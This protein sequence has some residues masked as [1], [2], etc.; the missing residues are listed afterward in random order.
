MTE[1]RVIVERAGPPKP[2]VGQ[3]VRLDVQLWRPETGPDPLP[4]FSFDEIEM[5][6]A[7]TL[8]RPE[9]PPPEER[10]EGDVK[11]L[12]QHRTLLV[13]PQ[14]DG[15]LTV[16]P[17][18][19]R[20]N[21]GT[22]ARSAQSEPL[23]FLASY[24]GPETDN[25]L[26]APNVHLEQNTNRALSGLRVGD[27]FTRTVKLSAMDSDPIV[28]PTLEFV[29][30]GG[31]ALYSNA[32]HAES[33]AERG[34][35]TASQSYSVTYVVERV[36]HYELPGLSIRYLEPS[37]GRFLRTE[38]PA[39]DFWVAPNPHLGLAMWGTAPGVAWLGFGLPLVLLVG[40]GGL[41]LRRKRNGPWAWEQRF[42]AR[43]VEQRAFAS[44]LKTT[45]AGTAVRILEATYAWL[46]LRLPEN[47]ERTLR[48]LRQ[49]CVETAETLNQYEGEAFGGNPPQPASTKVKRL[50]RRA[51]RLLAKP[52]RKELSLN[53][54]SATPGRR[55]GL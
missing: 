54:E 52:P 49:T 26:I 47:Q 33:S 44:L 22:E 51:R 37:S 50:L 4:P 25:L 28:F 24:V 14:T 6:G 35:L 5:Q 18:K 16:P 55:E 15:Q 39:L 21:E 1:P 11:F 40:L 27:G 19:A 36:G 17:I 43:R 7:I 46:F 3:L 23:A 9:A 32:P 45:E 13:F 48:P 29:S 10:Q 2:W 30:E 20:W 31:L 34:Q 42:H 53:L 8:F 12:V 41:L 38:V